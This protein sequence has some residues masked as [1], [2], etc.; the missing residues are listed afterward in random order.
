MTRTEEYREIAYHNGMSNDWWP[1]SQL[2]INKAMLDNPPIYAHNLRRA[3]IECA[4]MDEYPA[5]VNNLELLVGRFSEGYELTEEDKKVME[6]E[7][8]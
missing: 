1:R 3:Q 8:W 2:S 5:V 7:L 4:I 6:L